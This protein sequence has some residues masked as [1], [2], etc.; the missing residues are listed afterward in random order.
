MKPSGGPPVSYQTSSYGDKYLGESAPS[1]EY[2][3][4]PI[5]QAGPPGSPQWAQTGY[6]TLKHPVNG[7]P[8][9]NDAASGVSSFEVFQDTHIS[10]S[11][12]GAGADVPSEVD[13]SSPVES[14]EVDAEE[15]P[16]NGPLSEV[17]EGSSASGSPFGTNSDPALNSLQPVGAGDVSDASPSPSS[18]LATTSSPASDDDDDDYDLSPF[19]IL[20]SIA[21]V[22]SY[23][24]F[25]NP[26]HY[27]FFSLAAAPFTALAAGVLGIVTFLFPWALP[28]PLS[29]ANDN[30]FRYWPNV[31]EIDR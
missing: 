11:D 1:A 19:G 5:Y 23:F 16:Q 31:E 24:T 25:E 2:Q 10:L 18:E 3:P 4:V 30:A 9:E 15:V 6:N 14:T 17:L 29:R 13:T 26:L 21:S 28:S 8:Q 27:G 12:L 20:D 22:F 7:V